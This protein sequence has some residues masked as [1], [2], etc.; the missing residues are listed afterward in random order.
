MTQK[1]DLQDVTTDFED[2]VYVIADEV[3][4]ILKEL[5]QECFGA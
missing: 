2:K 5:S 1:I 3:L 4:N